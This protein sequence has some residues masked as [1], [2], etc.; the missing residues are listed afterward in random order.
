MYLPMSENILR[1]SHV[2]EISILYVFSMYLPLNNISR[3]FCY[4]YKA[5][6]FL[7]TPKAI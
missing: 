6:C 4:F 1:L 2:L 5:I 7:T 3:L